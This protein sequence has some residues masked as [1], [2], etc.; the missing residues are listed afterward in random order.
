MHQALG[1]PAASLGRGVDAVGHRGVG[2]G[3]ESVPLACGGEGAAVVG[4][5]VGG[6]D[7]GEGEGGGGAVAGAGSQASL[8][9]HPCNHLCFPPGGGHTPHGDGEIHDHVVLTTL[10]SM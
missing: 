9:H 1:Q 10:S 7:G 4:V 3:G 2:L 8:L 5:G 6:D